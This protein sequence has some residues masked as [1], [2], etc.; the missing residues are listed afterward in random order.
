MTE[1]NIGVACAPFSNKIYA[2]KL[3]ADR[4]SFL[5]GKRDVTNQACEAVA[6]HVL[7]EYGEGPKDGMVLRAGAEAWSI[8]VERI[9]PTE[10]TSGSGS[11]EGSEGHEPGRSEGGGGD[12]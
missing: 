2:G 12:G 6:R 1:Q 5:D 9:D 3:S 4:A 8:T 7:K 10:M 11:V